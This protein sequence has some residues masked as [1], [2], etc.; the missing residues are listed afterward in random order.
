V[1]IAGAIVVAA[2]ILLGGC[3]EL[4]STDTR[5]VTA[6]PASIALPDGRTVQLPPVSY[7]SNKEQDWLLKVSPDGGLEMRI[8]APNSPGMTADEMATV[9]QATGA[10]TTQTVRQLL[11]AGLPIAAADDPT[12]PRIPTP[13]VKPPSVLETEDDD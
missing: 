7:D 1:A 3:A 5:I 10:T 9:I 6:G 12:G 4:S 11:A 2:A 13:V 8:R